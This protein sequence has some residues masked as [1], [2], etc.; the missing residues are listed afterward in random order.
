MN[1]LKGLNRCDTVYCVLV[2]WAREHND[3]LIASTLGGF[4]AGQPSERALLQ[5]LQTV[6]QQDLD[7]AKQVATNHEATNDAD[8]AALRSLLA[9]VRGAL[10]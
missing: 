6:I 3:A 2:M 7:A 4:R 8:A 10:Q 9:H 1:A 5:Q